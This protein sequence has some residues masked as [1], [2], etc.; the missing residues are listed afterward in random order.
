MVVDFS[1]MPIGEG[2][3]LSR[4]VAAV[5]K[6]IV[7]SGLPYRVGP[8]ATTIEGQ[9]GEVMD[10]VK[11]CRDEMFENCNRIHIILK[12]DDRKGS[13]NRLR[14][15]VKSVEEKLGKSLK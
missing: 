7:E 5:V 8:M 11:R 12:I 4:H 2:E 6:L 15:K 9:W 14:G 3:S 1:I 13:T 10:L